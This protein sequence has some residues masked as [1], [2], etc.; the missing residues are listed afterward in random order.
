MRKP[1]MIFQE[2]QEVFL[3]ALADDFDPVFNDAEIFEEIPEAQDDE[4]HNLA[5]KQ[6]NWI[7]LEI[8]LNQAGCTD[9]T[10]G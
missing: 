9:W 1:K 7:C 3:E 2:W 6:N 4:E 5:M 8:F 10:T